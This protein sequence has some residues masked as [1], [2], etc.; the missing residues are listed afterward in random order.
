MDYPADVALQ[1]TRRIAVQHPVAERFEIVYPMD[2][3]KEITDFN[4]TKP[5]FASL[6][7]TA[8]EKRKAYVQLVISDFLSENKASVD[9]KVL[10][11]FFRM[12]CVWC[13]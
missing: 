1:I 10:G 4:P 9:G 5:S 3:R 7:G 13:F 12:F 2:T 8:E 6:P 11:F